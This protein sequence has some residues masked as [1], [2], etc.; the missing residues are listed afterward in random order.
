MHDNGFHL[1]RSYI[2]QLVGEALTR[3]SEA[4]YKK[5]LNLD[6]HMKWQREILALTNDLYQIK[7]RM[8]V[9]IWKYQDDLGID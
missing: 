5:R 2:N 9:L 4:E 1:S 3:M 7:K 8:D 6:K